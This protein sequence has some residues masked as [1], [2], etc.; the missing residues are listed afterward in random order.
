MATKCIKSRIT[1]LEFKDIP[2]KPVNFNYFFLKDLQHLKNK[3]S[4]QGCKDIHPLK[5]SKNINYHDLLDGHLTR[6]MQFKKYFVILELLYLQKGFETN[7]V[8]LYIFLIQSPLLLTNCIS[9]VGFSQ[10]ITSPYL[11]T[12]YK[13]FPNVPF[14]FLDPIHDT[15]IH[16]FIT[17]L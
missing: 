14:C 6:S 4:W 17:F 7:T 15:T 2:T 8:N 11:F 5:N 1:L 16:L 12:I 3:M 9:I 13:V 10:I